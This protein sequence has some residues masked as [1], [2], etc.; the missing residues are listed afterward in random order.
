MS[1]GCKTAH[2]TSSLGLYR[3]VEDTLR[4]TS[5]I[6][7]QGI[8]L[9]P[10]QGSVEA[11]AVHWRSRLPSFGDSSEGAIGIEVGGFHSKTS[12]LGK[13]TTTAS[14]EEFPAE[15]C[16]LHRLHDKCQLNLLKKY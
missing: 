15:K 3:R 9:L 14:Q 4:R 12:L 16:E 7:K 1:V 8:K 6:L 13:G 11:K 2:T 10:L 5:L